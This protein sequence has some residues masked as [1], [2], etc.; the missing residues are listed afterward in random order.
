MD[1]LY[2]END[3][4]KVYLRTIKNIPYLVTISTSGEL[5]GIKPYIGEDKNINVSSTSKRNIEFGC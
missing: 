1:R 2:S 3:K 5:I 4:E